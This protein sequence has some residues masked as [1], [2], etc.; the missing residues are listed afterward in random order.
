MAFCSNCGSQLSKTSKFC[1]SCGTNITLTSNESRELN[2]SNSPLVNTKASTQPQHKSLTLSPIGKEKFSKTKKIVISFLGLIILV[3]GYMTLG[4]IFETATMTTTSENVPTRDEEN[5]TR[6]S[7]ISSLV[8]QGAVI[9]E[10]I[11]A[12]LL[13]ELIIFTKSYGYKCDTVSSARPFMNDKGY[14]LNCNNYRYEYEIE[15]KGGNFVITVK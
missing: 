11:S 14:Q 7:S 9:N 5:T 3:T 13:K 10:K 6:F 2:T 12:D 1:S 15:D 4:A 8:E